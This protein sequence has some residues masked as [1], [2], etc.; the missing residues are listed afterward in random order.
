MERLPFSKKIIYAIG[1]L[2]W[3]ICINVINFQLVYFY[4]P[5]EDA[6]LP[7]FIT[8]VV[9]LGIL[10]VVTLVLASGRLFDAITDPFIASLSDNWKSKLGRRIPF[11][12]IGAIPT[13][14]F[15]VLL[16]YPPI[17]GISATNII[18]LIIIQLLFYFSLTVYLTPFFALIPELGH[19]ADQRLSIAT[20]LSITYALGMMI[21]SLVPNIADL[22]ANMFEI[23]GRVQAIQ[24]GL[25][26]LGVLAAIFML[27]P[28]FFI[29]EKRYTK[30]AEKS[31]PMREAL[32][33]CFQNE[34]FKYYVVAE[35]AYF[36]AIAIV[37]AGLLYYVTVLMELE[38]SMSGVLFPIMVV[39]SFIGYPFVYSLAKK[40]G[41]KRF[42][43]WAFLFMFVLFLGIYFIGKY[44]VP[45]MVQ[46]Y[47]MVVGLAIPI[48]FLGVL[49]NAILADIA[50][51]DAEVTGVAQEGMY[52]A[53][54][55]LMQK[56]GQTL[57]VF[58]FAALTSLGNSIGDDLGI[59]L[60]ALIGSVL[61]LFAGIY[62]RKY[63][64]EAVLGVE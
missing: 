32:R 23:S 13:A 20:W 10:N 43:V 49:P 62:F 22:F 52:F 39:L 1:Q 28:A 53:A 38:E 57:G 50:K 26:F 25:I 45:V 17:A 54:R 11:M 61:C 18:W 56:L 64:E 29:D 5:P 40:Y 16:F 19:D 42:V 12:R 37:M 33:R 63:N 59:R 46:A 9:F 41:K 48:S 2:G 60:S 14:L 35:L 21:G 7:N 15:M 58:T 27:L 3:A 8:T 51:K 30:P 31:V 36:M 55:T 47:A 6:G 44:P 34:S 24:A 4:L